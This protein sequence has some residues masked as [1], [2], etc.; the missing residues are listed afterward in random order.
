ML[1]IILLIRLTRRIGEMLKAKGRKSGWF[2]FLTVVLW[3]GG[4]FIGGLIG[5]VIAAL[6]GWSNILAYLIALIG[7]AIGAG[8][9]YFIARSLPPLEIQPPPPPPTFH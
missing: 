9:A 2:K 7:A 3:F 4:E 6:N 5:G 1:E 8:T